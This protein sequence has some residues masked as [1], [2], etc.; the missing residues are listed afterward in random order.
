L[1]LPAHTD[2]DSAWRA[3][4]DELRAAVTQSTYEIW[5]A[6][7]ELE[8]WDQNTLALR[9]PPTTVGWVSKRFS[10]LI[11]R[12]AAHGPRVQRKGRIRR[13]GGRSLDRGRR[14]RRADDRARQWL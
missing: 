7:L 11:E 6:R 1:A 5:L 9:A 13:P 14:G 2:P 10:Q 12:T 4:R 8:A 3:I